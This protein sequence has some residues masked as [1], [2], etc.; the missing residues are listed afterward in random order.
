[1]DLASA[2]V[3]PGFVLAWIVAVTG[4][5]F[6]VLNWVCPSVSDR[7]ASTESRGLLEVGGQPDGTTVG[8]S[9]WVEEF[10]GLI[11]VFHGDP[12]DLIQAGQEDPEGQAEGRE[13][14]APTPMAT[15]TMAKPGAGSRPPL[16]ALA[17]PSATHLLPAGVAFGPLALHW[18]SSGL[19]VDEAEAEVELQVIRAGR[20]FYLLR[21]LLARYQELGLDALPEELLAALPERLLRRLAKDSSGEGG[22]KDS[23]DGGGSRLGL[24]REA[25]DQL[26]PQ[27]RLGIRSKASSFLMLLSEEELRRFRMRLQAAKRHLAAS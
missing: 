20:G 21:L 19:E 3:R 12:H 13:V 2:P 1:M 5:A 10:R 15:A 27:T 22:G 6:L 26:D 23:G 4:S 17:L 14:D 16:Q 24:S 11:P 18:S 8:Q 7:I 9:A 25:W